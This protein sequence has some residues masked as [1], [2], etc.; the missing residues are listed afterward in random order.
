MMTRSD[1]CIHIRLALLSLGR[2]PHEKL[3][4]EKAA[5]EAKFDLLRIEQKRRGNILKA[6]A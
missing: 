1:L 4:R 5:L 3:P 2:D 6:S